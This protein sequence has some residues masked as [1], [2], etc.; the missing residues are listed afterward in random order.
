M[1]NP[2]ANKATAG[3]VVH[4][5][6]L[7]SRGRFLAEKTGLLC[8]TFPGWRSG[9]RRTAPLF[10][11]RF[12]FWKSTI[13]RQWYWHLKDERNEKLAQG[14]AYPTKEACLRAIEAVRK[15]ATATVQDLSLLNT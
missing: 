8:G 9:P 2:K 10:P 15:C 6:N 4:R 1:A 3:A 12:E 7:R 5:V 13:D 11:V 14:E